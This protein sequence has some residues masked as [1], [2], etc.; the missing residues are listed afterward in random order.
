MESI[1]AEQWTQIQQLEQAFV[2]IKV[3]KFMLHYFYFS[4]S[5][6]T[7]YF[8]FITISVSVLFCC[9]VDDDIKGY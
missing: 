6:D 3:N 1:I 9:S 5:H 7:E 8:L 4:Y 2:L